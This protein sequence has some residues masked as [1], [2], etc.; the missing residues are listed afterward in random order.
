MRRFLAGCLCI[1][2]AVWMAAAGAEPLQDRLDALMKK[3]RAVGAAVVAAQ[4][5]RIFLRYT[6]GYEDRASERPVTMDTRFR[7]ASVTKMISALRVMQLVEQGRLDLDRDISDLLGYPVEN[8]FAEGKITLRMLMSHT[9]S[10]AGPGYRFPGRTL[11]ELIGDRKRTRNRFLNQRPGKKYV[12]SNLGAGIMGTLIELAEGKNVD[13]ALREGVFAPLHIDAGFS[14]QTLRDPSHVASLYNEGG[15]GLRRGPHKWTEMAWD[16][17]PDP[18]LH[19]DLTVGD[20]LIG[21]EDLCRLGMMLAA[22]G[23]LNGVRLLEEK[24]VQEMTADQRGKPGILAQS[25]YGLCVH[26]EQ[27]LLPG[28]TLFGH[29][30]HMWGTLCSLYW[31]PETRTV[32]L[33]VSN[34]CAVTLKSNT[35]VLAAKIWEMIWNG[36]ADAQPALVAD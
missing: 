13:T 25:P 7:I 17:V 24:T 8:P 34:G 27:R 15:N 23:A 30:G 28:H 22:G 29:Q 19:Y 9:S 32:V 20:L 26:R 11:R 31:E 12:Y 36:N 21:P 1:L 4:N 14:P 18:E 16:G 5:G 6:Y 33:L 10:L 2:L 3:Y 35:S